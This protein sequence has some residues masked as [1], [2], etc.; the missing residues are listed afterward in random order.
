MVS[1][2]YSALSGA[3]AR[4]QTIANISANLANV[5]TSGYK[6]SQVGFESLLRGEQQ[7]QQAKGLNYSRIK[8]VSSD[9]S[10]GPMRETANPLDMAINGEG[11]FKI[12]G[13]TGP[14][15]TRRGDFVVDADGTLRT[16]NGMAVLDEANGEITIPD[17]DTGSIAAAENGT[18]Y[19]LTPDGGRNE[20]ARLAVVTIDDPQKLQREENTTF[21]LQDGGNETPLEAPQVVQGSLEISNVNMT[22]E[23][24]QMINNY[25]TFETYHKVLESY[26]VLG[27]QQDELGT[28]G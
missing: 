25:R 28:V 4:E 23:M 1:G 2:K 3:I 14:R 9:F 7:I 24:A 15:Y 5:N 26:K 22:E 10:P 21:S 27:E 13:P 12:Q 6:R 11:F 20:V 19:L 18:L 17:T 8:E 16:T